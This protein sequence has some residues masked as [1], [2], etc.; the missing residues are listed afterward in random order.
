MEA[1]AMN[2]IERGKSPM[3][4]LIETVATGLGS[5]V[6]W[7]ADHGILFGVFALIWV[8]FGIG[9]VVSQGSIDQA[10]HTIRGLPLLVQL[11]AWLLFLPVMAGLWIWETSWPLVVRLV[12]VLSIA[13]WNLLVFLPKPGQAAGA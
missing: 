9:L 11:V 13:G 1:T 4:Q 12:L 2:V 3:E 6:G 7:L 10:W 8:A 5:S